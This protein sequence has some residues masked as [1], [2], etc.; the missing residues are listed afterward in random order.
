MMKVLPERVREQC[1]ICYGHRKDFKEQK[2]IIVKEQ[3][4]IISAP[5]KVYQNS[6]L[7]QP[8]TL[9]SINRS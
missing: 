6:N 8:K 7:V 3:N 4:K 1:L 5:E 9:L 2:K